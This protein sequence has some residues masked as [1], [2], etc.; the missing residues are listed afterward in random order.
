MSWHYDGL[1]NFRESVANSVPLPAEAP[2]GEALNRVW[3]PL[4]A[5]A[6][7]VTCSCA[8]CATFVVVSFANVFEK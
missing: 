6:F 5:M 1:S 8:T 7:F 4:W 3:L 2:L